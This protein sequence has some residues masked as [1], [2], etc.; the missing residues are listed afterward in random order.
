MNKTFAFLA[1]VVALAGGPAVA[2]EGGGDPFPH[3]AT[4][5][6]SRGAAY[7]A[8]TGY[9]A[10]PQ[11]TGTRVFASTLDTLEPVAG[12]EQVV[13]TAASLPTRWNEGTV[14]TMQAQSVDRYLASRRVRVLEAGVPRPGG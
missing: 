1:V 5:Q 4:P 14:V 7:V 12:A 10:F 9:E 2:Q 11:L 6:Y 13:Q 3:A 8:E